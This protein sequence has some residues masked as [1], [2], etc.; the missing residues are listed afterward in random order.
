[1]WILL[2][3]TV[4]QFAISLVTGS[5]ALLADTIHNL[6]DA[7]TAVPLWIALVLG[8]RPPPVATRTGTDAPKISPTSSSCSS[9]PCQR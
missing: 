3:T 2:V 1:M 7:L 4:L 8:R 9:W 6:A 5:V